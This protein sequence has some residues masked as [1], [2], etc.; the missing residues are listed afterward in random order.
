MQQTD[1]LCSKLIEELV[2]RIRAV[3]ESVKKGIPTKKADEI[4]SKQKKEFV[5]M[6][7][8]L[9]NKI[10]SA[11]EDMKTEVLNSQRKPDKP[12]NALKKQANKENANSNNHKSLKNKRSTSMLKPPKE[13]LF[14]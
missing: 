14:K 5:F 12:K 10:K 1:S 8:S 4:L 13:Y 11:V 9:V 7:K 6:K 2:K 3:E